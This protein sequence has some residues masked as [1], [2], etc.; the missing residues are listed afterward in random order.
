[1]LVEPDAAD[2]RVTADAFGVA[3]PE[4]ELRVVASLSEARSALREGRISL[5]MASLVLP[6]G[7]GE[8]LI[9]RAEGDPP[10]ILLT[11]AA[12]AERAVRAVYAGA[13]E[14]VIKHP[15]A[16]RDLPRVARR[17]LAEVERRPR[18]PLTWGD[19]RA[20]RSAVE[21]LTAGLG[22]GFAVISK[23]FRILMASDHLREVLGAEEGRTCYEAFWGR[24]DACPE[25]VVRE[26]FETGAERTIHEHAGV[27]SQGRTVWFQIMAAPLL[28]ETG[29]VAAAVELLVPVT[30][31]KRVEEALRQRLVLERLLETISTR[32]LS[33]DNLDE[34]QSWCLAR[35]GEALDVSRTYIFAHDHGR[36]LMDNTHEWVAPGIEPQR[37]QLQGIPTSEIRWWV[38]QL[39]GNV[40]INYRDVEDI[41]SEPVR[42]ILRAQNIRS[43][44]AV[45][46][47]VEKTYYGF[48]G[49]D[50]CRKNR[51]WAPEDVDILR[52]VAQIS[53]GVVERKR[54]EAA[55]RASEAEYRRLSREFHALLDAIPDTLTLLSRDREVL[56]V[57]RGAARHLG[58]EVGD[59]VGRR[60]YTIWHDR[61]DPCEDCP[62]QVCLE[63]GEPSVG[64]VESPDGRVWELRVVPIR[65]D[66][67]EVVS[68]VEL[69][70]DITD[71]CVAEAEREALIEELEAKNSE[72][73]QFTHTVSH[74]LKTPLTTVRGFIAL[75]DREM[76]S[77]RVER[78]RGYAKRAAEAADNMGRFLDELLDL[79]RSGRPTHSPEELSFAEIVAEALTMA[80]GQLQAR[81]VRVH[82]QDDLPQVRGDPVRLRE[83]L[84]NLLSNAAKFMGDQTEPRVWV[85][86]ERRGG[87][88]VFW[89]RDNGLGVAHEDREH[90]F[91]A[92]DKVDATGEGLGLGLAIARRIVEAHGGEIWVESEG[93]P[94]EGS[95]F[96]FTLT[97][98]GGLLQ[99]E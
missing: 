61:V 83:V 98:S 68:A 33:S 54:S 26:V 80:H 81:G 89:V 11:P 91:G 13:R 47:F 2:A 90:I 43:I 15:A 16:L 79:S 5:I 19:L 6:D 99:G 51:E 50:E 29:G 8:S 49:F 96:C 9:S 39:R 7:D 57:N 23:D 71:F 12:D 40:V 17:V 21:A 94:G 88:T 36:D 34:F 22:V 87:H 62:T 58:L 55:L 31:R 67:G 92:F 66:E 53:A 95:C 14:Y 86:A 73:E 24:R 42:E 69:A 65:N 52:T 46:L 45:P 74:D 41:P 30:E 25:C 60:C 28:D 84:Q 44:L 63:S 38:E 56:W 3:V 82:V 48:M 18:L 10:V 59:L 35:M 76:A 75:M 72:L 20:Q 78:V 97:P 77:G 64:L 85:G 70:R 27:D 93:R 32:A 1:M 37:G 4:Y